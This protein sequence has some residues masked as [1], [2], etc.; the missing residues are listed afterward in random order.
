[1]NLSFDAKVVLITGAS[2]GIG[3][4]SAKAF[5]E[6]GAITVLADNQEQK[7]RGAAE[8]LAAAGHQAAAVTCD[9]TDPAQVQAMIDQTVSAHGRLDAAFNNAGAISD[10]IEILDTDDGEFDRLVSIN[11]RGLWLCMKAELRQMVAQGGGAI[12][13]CSSIGGLTGALGHGA[14]A[15]TKHGVMGLTSSAALEYIAKG[16]RINAV[17]PGMIDTPM[18]DRVS[19]GHDPEVV[20]RMLREQPIG[21]FGTS[22]EIAAAVLWL[23]SDAASL[24]VGHTLPVDGGYMAR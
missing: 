3:F 16:V 9:V 13:N 21:R 22:G 23:C 15:A 17:A 1:M 18:N 11:L 24:V 14:Y 8:Q 7:V 6:A 10:T 4:A 19:E 2:Q 20:D 12:V 5:A